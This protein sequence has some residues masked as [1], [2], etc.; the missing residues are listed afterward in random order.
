[1]SDTLPYPSLFKKTTKKLNH[2][3]PISIPQ[4]IPTASLNDKITIEKKDISDYILVYGTSVDRLKKLEEVKS[5]R[6]IETGRNWIK[7]VFKS[8]ELY[9]RCLNVDRR[10]LNGEIIG[11]YRS[12]NLIEKKV[13]IG[14]GILQR[15]KE[16]FFG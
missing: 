14:K 3:K 16:Y 6:V 12:V 4:N 1:M 2:T 7:V 15:V 9:F 10:D 11:C 8:E 13:E 5:G